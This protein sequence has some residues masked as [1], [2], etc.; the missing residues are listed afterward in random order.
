MYLQKILMDL[1]KKNLNF[2][3]DFNL[4]KSYLFEIENTQLSVNF[5]LLCSLQVAYNFNDKR[6]AILKGINVMASLRTYD[7]F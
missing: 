4:K 1:L 7:F 3:S 2:K 5:I 6:Y